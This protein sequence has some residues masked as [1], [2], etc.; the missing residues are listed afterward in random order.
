[1]SEV[2]LWGG[3]ADGKRIVFPDPVPPWV[4]ISVPTEGPPPDDPK[5]VRIEPGR[6]VLSVEQA[7]D[8]DLVRYEWEEA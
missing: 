4:T 1:M 3:P 6:Y 8:I 5:L 2:E 7:A